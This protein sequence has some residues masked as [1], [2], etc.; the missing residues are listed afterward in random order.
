MSANFSFCR[1]FAIFPNAE[2]AGRGMCRR[3]PIPQAHR[4]NADEALLPISRG[5]RNG[6]SSPFSLFAF[7]RLRIQTELC[8]SATL[9]R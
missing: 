9:L 8:P 7:P 3:I 1:D 2:D 6:L 5:F 4:D